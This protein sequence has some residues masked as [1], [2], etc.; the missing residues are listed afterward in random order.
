MIYIEAI[1]HGLMFMTDWT[2]KFLAMSDK[3]FSFFFAFTEITLRSQKIESKTPRFQGK[4]LSIYQ[5][6]LAIEVDRSWPVIFGIHPKSSHNNLLLIE[7]FCEDASTIQFIAFSTDIRT[8]KPVSGPMNVVRRTIY[9]CFWWA[10]MI[11]R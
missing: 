1:S 7:I 4:T 6:L 11:P 9:A 2:D 3:F 10:D 5:V 8:K